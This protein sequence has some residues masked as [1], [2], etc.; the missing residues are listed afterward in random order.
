MSLPPSSN[1]RNPITFPSF[2]NL[3]AD[4]D[5]DPLYYAPNPQTGIYTP[6]RHWAFLAEIVDFT[7][8]IRLQ[9]NVK[10]NSGL[11]LP[12]WIHTDDRGKG[13]AQQCQQGSTLVVTYAEQHYFMDGSV[14]IKLEEDFSFHV[15]P[16]SMTDLLAANDAVFQEDRKEKCAS[17]GTK[18]EDKG[19]SLKMCSRC[20]VILYCGKVSHSYLCHMGVICLS[21]HSFLVCRSARLKHGGR[22][23]KKSAKS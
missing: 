6:T 22:S 18:G 17:C 11:V 8:F 19:D 3:P 12:V 20:K 16:H 7:T 10:D 2:A 1:L 15:L 9:V 4:N 21:S 13:L 14:G 5:I 23:I